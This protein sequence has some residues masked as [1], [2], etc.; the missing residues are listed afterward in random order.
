MEEDLSTSLAMIHRMKN[1]CTS[2]TYNLPPEILA[3]VGSR[4]DY[5]SLISAIQ[6][7][8]LW[9]TVLL[10]SPLLWSHFA[11]EWGD[12]RIL[13]LLEISKSVP[14]SVDFKRRS[15][16][17]EVVGT[18]LK[19]ISDRLI[20]LQAVD[21]SFLNELLVKPLP[22]LRSLDVITSGDL[23]SVKSLAA[24]N[25]DPPL[26]H[27]P[28]LTSFCFK[29]IYHPRSSVA[30]PRMGDNLLDFLRNCPL[31]EVAFFDYGDPCT[32]IEFTTDEESTE[33][34][35]LPY[36]RSF[37][38]KSPVEIVHIGLFNRL[39]LQPTCDVAF[40]VTDGIAVKQWEGAFPAPRDPSYL[41]DVKEVK[42]AVHHG[43]SGSV[44]IS[45]TFL[46][47]R[48]TKVSL[49]RGAHFPPW[50]DSFWVIENFLDFL[51][52]NKVGRSVESLHF[53]RCRVLM[54]PRYTPR[55]L[56]APLL[57]LGSLETIVLSKQSNPAFL[58]MNPPQPA[59]WCPR[60]E[61]LVVHLELPTIA[62]YIREPTERDVL[63]RVRD[64]A[65][66]RWKYATPFK[67]VTLFLE[68]V[69]T[70]SQE[71]KLLIEEL[72]SYVGSVKVGSLRE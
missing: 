59:V 50:N 57:G 65:A 10:S 63:E 69:E 9:R 12:Q 60:V 37:T 41:A 35:S 46:N 26:F 45:A 71:C 42:I 21:I 2:V 8:N 32:D 67:T 44:V 1:R 33:A 18:S 28:N 7:C 27:V 31:L 4:L 72:R 49:N 52:S 43:E 14:V 16:P 62:S 36:L 24:T 48:D 64:I 29:L 68:D 22:T 56:T 34:V 70:Q 55:G 40:T 51:G 61:N 17:S 15:V 30:T 11:S 25:L 66:S 58:L 3:T 6:T 13:W 20:S 53:E 39:S 54:P 47:S 38:H 23:L 5:E 19:R